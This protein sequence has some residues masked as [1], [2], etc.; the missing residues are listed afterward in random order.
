MVEGHQEDSNRL[1]RFI[2]SARD[3][4]LVEEIRQV[5]YRVSRCRA[6]TFLAGRLDGVGKYVVVLLVEV[7]AEDAGD[8]SWELTPGNEAG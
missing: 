1:G 6:R 2:R 7:H 5:D 3:R 8:Q 4:V